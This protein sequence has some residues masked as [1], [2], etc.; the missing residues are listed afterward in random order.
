MA[1]QPDRSAPDS[2]ADSS[3]DSSAEPGP[4]PVASRRA[5]MA[6]RL[7]AVAVTLLLAVAIA[8][9]VVVAA[10]PPSVDELRRAAGL[11]GKRELL[12]GVKDDQPGVA[13]RRPDGTFVGFDIDIAYLIAEELDFRRSEVRFL[14]IESEDRARMQANDAQ[15]RR[16]G[17]DLVVASYSITPAREAAAGV[18][19]SAPYLFT[20]QSVVTLREHEPVSTLEDLR[21][22]PVCSL[23]TATS[24]TAAQRA[25][26]T[27]V[28]RKK[29]SECF[30]A[31]RAG[32]VEAVSTD[33]AILAGFVA[34]D[35]EKLR[36][37]DI[38][39]D[40]AEAW[41][42][43]VGEND[44]LR[45]LVNLALRRS[46]E[47]PADARWEDAFDEH[48]RSLEPVN[49]PA[50]IAVAQQPAVGEVRVRQWPWERVALPAA[51]G[52]R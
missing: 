12:V 32:T 6:F 36:H 18:T 20:E 8:Y 10:G 33:A 26:A 28:S 17:V 27:V 31:L 11:D 40:V 22:R 45:D 1:E 35:P 30:T 16:V 5:A 42:V 24:E 9:V 34:R 43:N 14:G 4:Q 3:P 21:G 37:H 38:G 46:R 23:A 29:I 49:S 2:S 44:A 41:G 13:E 7:V 25:G 50:P 47:D 52:G 39:L 51:L 19:F 48:L 15:G